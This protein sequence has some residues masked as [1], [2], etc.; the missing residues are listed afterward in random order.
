VRIIGIDLSLTSTGIATPEGTE[1]YGSKH[2]GP[3]RLIEL[4]QDVLAACVDADFAVMEGYSFGSGARAHSM[5][6][7][8]G[9][10]RVALYENHIPVA[11]VPPASLKKYATGKGNAP[12]E[13]VLA[14][15]VR[16]SNIEFDSTDLADAWWLRAMGHDA[17]ERPIVEMPTLHRT[18]LQ[19]VIWPIARDG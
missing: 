4:R 5:G 10:V 18:A 1:T 3:E 19:A 12:K 6:E 16:R 11:I 14:A 13:A 17:V 8:G 15:A 7:L 9:V 2:R